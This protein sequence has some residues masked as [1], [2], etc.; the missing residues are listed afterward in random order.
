MLM[1][2]LAGFVVLGVDR[3]ERVTFDRHLLSLVVRESIARS[4]FWILRPL[5]VISSAP[6]RVPVP[7]GPERPPVLLVS[8]S[9]INRAALMFLRS[10]LTHRGIAWA[11]SVDVAHDRTGIV[12]AAQKLEGSVQRLCEASGVRAVDVVAYGSGGLV[13]AWYA[14][15]LDGEGRI[16]RLVT[17]GTPWRGTRLSVFR[18]GRL[19]EE[20]AYNA[21]LLDDL[22]PAIPTVS[23]W[24][25][26]DPTVVPSTSACPTAVQSVEIEGA[27]HAD[28]LV[29][30]RVYRAVQA[31]LS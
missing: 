16:R 4:L 14:R 19:G 26:D 15:H 30:A 24:S 22:V 28:M 18:R 10:F 31:A 23:I 8:G 6:V 25:P 2:S 13:A 21:H 12:E 29:S 9:S 20:L 1:A 3:G 17:I 27:G 7:D 5:G 11:W